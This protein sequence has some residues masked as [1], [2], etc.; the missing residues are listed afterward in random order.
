MRKHNS[1]FTLI[2]VIV[3]VLIIGVLASIAIP[4][5]KRHVLKTNRMSEAVPELTSLSQ[6]LQRC[7]TA[8]GRFNDDSC[9]VYKELDLGGYVTPGKGYYEISISNVSPTAYTLTATAILSQAEDTENGCNE[10][11]LNHLGQKEP[12]VCW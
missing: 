5:Y 3:V 10:L 1:G 9:A 7:Y 8:Y 2:E 6:R 11:K 12:M 4:Q